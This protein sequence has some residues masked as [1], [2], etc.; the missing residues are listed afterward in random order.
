MPSGSQA[1]AQKASDGPSWQALSYTWGD[2]DDVEIIFVVESE[3]G[4]SFELSVTKSLIEALRHLRYP[5]RDR[6]MWVDAI[7]IDQANDPI[8][9]TERAW[10]VGSMHHIYRQADAVIIWLGPEADDSSYALQ[11][12]E[13][14]SSGIEAHWWTFQISTDG[15]ELTPAM[16]RFKETAYASREQR[17]LCALMDRP[18]FE[19]LWV[20]QEVL[21]AE[22]SKSLVVVGSRSI[23]FAAFRT[24]ALA[25]NHLGLDVTSPNAEH[26]GDRLNCLI[27]LC[28]RTHNDARNLMRRARRSTC[29]DGRDKIYGQLGIM[30]RNGRPDLS[31]VES[32]EVDYSEANTVEKTYLDFFI[33]FLE[34][35]NILTLLIDSGLSQN[36]DIRP[37]WVPDWRKTLPLNLDPMMESAISVFY[38]P[39][40]YCPDDR[41]LAVKARYAI[42]VSD[43]RHLSPSIS[44]EGSVEWYEELAALL[45]DK[46]PPH[47]VDG[48][49]ESFTRAITRFLM[50]EGKSLDAI[51]HTLTSSRE[52]LKVLYE[53]ESDQNAVQTPQNY[54]DEEMADKFESCI[55]WLK[56]F[57]CPFIFSADGHVGFRP[58]GAQIGDEV[59]AILGCRCLMLLRPFPE[60][61]RYQVVGQCFVHG[62]NCG[63]ALLGPLPDETTII[64]RFEPSIPRFL[65]YYV[66]TNTGIESMWDPRIDWQGFDVTPPMAGFAFMG[67]PPG[68]PHRATPE[69]EYLESHGIELQTLI[70][71]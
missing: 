6:L 42:T 17:A 4:E 54:M 59:F 29:R 24:G 21:F 18:Y 37:T 23:S 25:L 52:Y 1:E 39:E 33:S 44:L 61:S 3:T 67:A 71:E 62:F 31:L 38:V 65:V 2:L 10:Q 32:I 45:R 14:L 58:N 9:L 22:E 68:E 69:S 46:I 28:N 66:N 53:A 47:D 30:A 43:V 11:V 26:E 64:T 5:D 41:L 20:V 50:H 63:E 19:R 36:T 49:I 13:D 60:R 48:G 12:L 16:Q 15:G 40:C 8:P 35:H 56:I 51:Q 34:T 7:C 27:N 70:L 55:R 57:R